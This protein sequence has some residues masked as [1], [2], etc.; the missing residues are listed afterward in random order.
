M[1]FLSAT[2]S[3][4]EGVLA[5]CGAFLETHSGAISALSAIFI[6]VFTYTLWRATTRLWRVSQRHAEHLEQSVAIA[7]V[8]AETASVS[9]TAADRHARAAI[10]AARPFVYLSKFERV[11][12]RENSFHILATFTNYG[13]SPAFRIKIGMGHTFAQNLPRQPKYHETEIAGTVIEPGGSL[14][15]TPLWRIVI[16]DKIRQ[17]TSD[18]KGNIFIW[19][20]IAYQDY[21]GGSTDMGFCYAYHAGIIIGGREF[22]PPGFFYPDDPSIDAY[23]YDRYHP[24]E[25]E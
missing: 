5:V 13:K 9:A 14:E 10:G 15:H 3:A 8:N 22:S 7:R 4:A 6:A 23:T 25:Q 17:E 19:G 24:A 11:G 20:R 12:I 18:N 21:M 2:L 1:S 16:S